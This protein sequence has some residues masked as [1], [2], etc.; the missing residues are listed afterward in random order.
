MKRQKSDFQKFNT[1]HDIS[2]INDR[3][4]LT[5]PVDTGKMYVTELQNFS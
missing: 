1:A 5:I 2:P 4:Y 3:K